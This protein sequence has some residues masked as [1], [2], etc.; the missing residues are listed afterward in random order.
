MPDNADSMD[1]SYNQGFAHTTRALQYAPDLLLSIHFNGFD[2]PDVGG[3]TV[4]YCDNGGPQNATLAGLMRDELA[5]AFAEIGYDPP[6]LEATEDGAIG[7]TY[8]HLA[9]LGNV[10]SA[11]FAYEGNRLA[12]VPAVLTEALFESNPTERALIEDDATLQAFARAYVRAIDAYFG[13]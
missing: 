2:D 6:Y 13:R 8:G 3:A 10:Y 1:L 9:T 11:P 5:G 12:G 4:Y 7:K